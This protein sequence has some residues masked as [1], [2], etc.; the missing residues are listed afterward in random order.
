MNA[1]WVTGVVCLAAGVGLGWG[2]ANRTS[3]E[4]AS[5]GPDP[6]ETV[7]VSH[8]DIGAS[9][10]ATGVVRPAVGAQVAVG[11]RVSGVLRSLHVT[12]GDRVEAGQL[13]AELDPTEFEAQ[14]RRAAASLAN[15]VAERTFA[16]AELER[17]TRMHE[18]GV[19]T[20]VELAQA[21]RAAATA[22]AKEQEAQAGLDGARVQLGYTR[23][24][25]PIRGI[26]G[27]VTTQEGETVAASFASPTFVTIVDLTRLEVQAYVDETDIGR[28]EIG[29]HARFTVD[30]WPGDAF[31][32]RVTAIR[33]T[34]ELRDN[35]V[36][37]VTLIQIDDRSGRALR[38]EMTAT[39]EILLAGRTGAVAIPND[40]LRRDADGSWVL[41]PADTGVE[42][43]YV[44]IG[45]R[46]AAF[47]E[48]LSGVE[49][50]EH[51]VLG[52]ALPCESAAET[53]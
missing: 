32:G 30:T 34:A 51:V 26:I 29:Q 17:V 44:E 5:I 23:I 18:P 1:A 47:T 14:V 4:R 10:L 16:D 48:V 25:S 15:A 38:P 2:S 31:A 46:G 28:I 36:N 19:V 22:R 43:R 8:R 37:Y 21:T 11:S 45:L 49:A 27:S 12:V 35:V 3:L 24:R 9:V 52:R 41:V 33:P 13:L 42:R 6:W 40:A 20:D 39:I 53:S 50:G 7:P